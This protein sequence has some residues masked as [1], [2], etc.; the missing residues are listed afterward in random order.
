MKYRLDFFL[1]T[2]RIDVNINKMNHNYVRVILL[3][4]DL[5]MLKKYVNKN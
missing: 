5:N 3:L 4:F 1:S 2:I